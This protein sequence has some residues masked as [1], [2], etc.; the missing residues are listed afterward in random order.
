MALISVTETV[1]ALG[2]DTRQLQKMSF[3]VNES[4]DAF[5]AVANAKNAITGITTSNFLNTGK[6]S[7]KDTLH[8]PPTLPDPNPF[9]TVPASRDTNRRASALPWQIY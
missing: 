2:P 4:A 6:A 5:W 9:R 3:N 8:S 1:P 7:F